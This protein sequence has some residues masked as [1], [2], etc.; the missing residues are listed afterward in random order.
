MKN[1][2]YLSIIKQVDTSFDLNYYIYTKIKK[3]NIEKVSSPLKVGLKITGKC[4]FRCQYC[5]VNKEKAYLSIE[6]TRKIIEKLPQLP[7]EIYITGGEATL[8][9]DFEPII[10]YLYSLGVLI[11]LHTT[12]VISDRTK[13]YII[14]NT[15]KFSSIQ[16]SIDSIKNF[17]KFRPN[18]V[19]KNS[20]LQIVKFVNECKNNGYNNFSINVVLS[21]LNI[22]EL[23]DIISFGIEKGIYYFRLSPIFTTNRELMADDERYIEMYRDIIYKYSGRGAVFLSDPLCHPWSY[24]IKHSTASCST[25]LFCPAQKTEFEVDM[26]GDVYP[27][28]FLYD[29]YHKMGNMLTDDFEDI[30]NSGVDELNVT[31]WSKNEK[32]QSCILFEDCGGG[33]YALAYASGKE[34]DLRCSLHESQ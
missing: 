13:Q 6:N 31:A 2:C 14:N 32:C 29:S 28:P 22:D 30:W 9:P 19:D 3:R 21:K 20:L 26:F 16:I 4:H 24:I 25:P 8:N 1:N 10:E 33:C 17:N 27:C 7:F 11:R 23:E 34:Y 12:G 5:F 15:Y 18:Y